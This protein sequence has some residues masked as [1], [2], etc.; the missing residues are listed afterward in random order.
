[1]LG[2][3][4]V[5]SFLIGT[6]LALPAVARPFSAQDV[7]T[8]CFAL[9][10]EPDRA[11]AALESE[12]WVRVPAEASGPFEGPIGIAFLAAQ[13]GSPEPL[14]GTA[15]G[16]DFWKESW[17]VGQTFLV[18]MLKKEGRSLFN[19]PETSAVLLVDVG[20]QKSTAKMSC[21]LAVPKAQTEGSSYFPKLRPPT[22]PALSL[23]ISDYLLT[24]ATRSN[25]WINSAALNPEE[26]SAALGIQT[27]IGAA[28]YS[29]VTHP[30]FL[31]EP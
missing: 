2:R 26:I 8:V 4:S 7:M 21:L 20:L 28:F 9:A 22:M 29:N 11:F 31:F 16:E 3:V 12:G 18:N 6:L 1:M 24:D 5:V 14:H 13:Y 27:N 23:A 19:H 30:K 15:S 17:P 10:P 25:F